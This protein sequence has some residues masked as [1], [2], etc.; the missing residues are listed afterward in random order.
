[1]PEKGGVMEVGTLKADL[2]VHTK[3]SKRPSEWILQKIGAAESYTEPLKVYDL[4]K[5]RGMNVFTIT[6]HN[7]IDGA[8]EIAHLDN[9]FLSEEIT[10]YYPDNGCKL[11]VLAWDISEAQHEE[12]QRLRRNVYDLVEYMQ[13]EDILHSLAHPM[14]DMNSRLTPEHFEKSLLLFKHMEL[15]G[16]RDD[17]QNGI[18]RT[19]TE[20]LPEDD[21]DMLA[22]KHGFAPKISEAWIKHLTAGS[23]DH[24]SLNIARSHTEVPAGDGD[25]VRTFLQ[26]LRNGTAVPLSRPATPRSMAHNLYSIAY[27]FYKDKFGLEKFVGR[28]LLLRF[29]DRALTNEEIPEKGIKA[30]LHELI[31]H[32]RANSAEKAMPKTV[33]GWFHKEALN[34][35]RNDKELMQSFRR[36]ENLPWESESDWFS[37]VDSASEKVLKNFADSILNSFKGADVF[38]VFSAVGS[39]GS[40]YIMLAPYV[41][42]YTYFSKDRNFCRVVD[43]RFSKSPKPKTGRR[44]IAHFTD[45]FGHANVVSETLKMQVHTAM[46]NKKHLTMITCGPRSHDGPGVKTFEPIGS[47]NMDAGKGTPLYY[48]PLLKILDYVYDLDVTHIHAATPG[49]MGM[50]ALAVSRMLKLPLRASHNAAF[51]HFAGKLT[52]DAAMEG[53]AWKYITWFYNQAD[54]V[55]VPSMMFAEE[56]VEHGVKREKIRHSPLGVDL[57]LFSPDKRNGFYTDRFPAQV[58]SAD[59]G[60]RILYVGRL[61]EEKNIKAV[62]DVLKALHKNIPHAQLVVVGDGPAMK[63]AKKA[64]KGTNAVFPGFLEGEELAQ[65]YASADVF[66]LPVTTGTFGNVVMEAQASGLPVVVGDAGAPKENV[67]DGE[68]GFVVAEAEADAFVAAVKSLAESKDSLAKM[69]AEARSHMEQHCFERTY[70]KHWHSYGVEDTPQANPETM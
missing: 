7:V 36:H 29:V 34:I 65:A 20:G 64:L 35:V 30:K 56:L 21:I 46:K 61:S 58:K 53:L 63:E 38:S 26:G 59:E 24:S 15:N 4:C 47:F 67:K 60:L 31:S 41:V 43:E 8:L 33:Q 22:D 27:Q 5:R 55:Y 39:A 32:I 9:T 51:S 40:S 16:S 45:T 25:A 62:A 70:L 18:L 49:P 1:M 54:K 50:A 14:Y 57:E 42:G 68:T 69:K 2:H 23:D 48:P 6:D 66:V 11:H 3:H 17:Y 28:D 10:T 44:R 37:F 52:Q 12:I 19:L 13:G